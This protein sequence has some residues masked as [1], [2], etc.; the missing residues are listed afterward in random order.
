MSLRTLFLASLCTGMLLPATASLAAEKNPALPARE[1][2]FESDIEPLLSRYNCNSS[3]C[4]GKAEGQN[5]FKLSVFGF[6]AKADHNALVREGRGRRISP[7]APDTSLLLLK[8]A[9][10]IP[11]GGGPRIFE[12][13]EEFQLL[14]DWIA[15]GAPFGR[16]D[17]PKVVR[18][19]LTPHERV[20]SMGAKQPLRVLATYSDGT[21]KDVTRLALFHSNNEGLVKV[22]ERGVV[23]AGHIPGQA[24]IMARFIGEVDVFQ[25]LVPRAEA[26]KEFAAPP[27][28]NFI[29]S[30]VDAQLKK[31]NILPSGLAD[32]AEFLRRVYLDVIG[33]L[34]TPAE[35]RKFLADSRADKRARLVDELIERPEFADYWAL[36]LADLLRVDRLKLTHREAYA[37]FKWIRDSLAA[38]VPFDRIVRELLTAEGPL[39]D[40]P[41]GYF[42]KVAAKPG[43]MANSLSQTFLGVRIACAECHHHPYDRWTQGDYQGMTTFFAQVNV[44]KGAQGEALVAEGSPQAKHPRTG[45]LIQPY[46]LGTRMPEKS[47]EGDRRRVLADWF[48]S[49]DNQW[50]AR[51]LANRLVAHFFGRGLVEPVDD[52]R[53][54]NPAS[55]PELLDALA[56]DVQGASFD[57]RKIIRTLTAS[58]TYQLSS[59][60][61]ETNE[62]DEQNYSRA[63][64]KRLPAEVLFDAVC[65]TTGVPEKFD[66]VSPGFRA[67]QLWDSQVQHYFLKLFGRP[68]RTSACECER[69]A[70]ASIAQ[71]LHLLNSPEIQEKLAHESGT[72]ATLVKSVSSDPALVDELYLTWFSRLPTD[73][74]KV[75]A[76]KFLKDSP[77]RRQGAEDLA[78]SLQNSL[79]F[80]FNH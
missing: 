29:D 31:L 9:G 10:I 18:V 41:A 45:E 34:P 73:A 71:V 39:D 37:Y 64:F 53:A 57:L 12:G 63:L 35:A 70:E 14:R 48:T 16:S 67:V 36:K 26:L 59:K 21:K 4:H 69:N 43:D 5:G 32:D 68:A 46:A 40:A 54:T 33:M 60:P 44:K 30:L 17:A 77:L 23:T 6:D 28:F 7:A 56:R 24:A 19:E 66:G 80:I 1:F 72:V 78:W 79:E 75:T 25:A 3:G 38:N 42:Y 74:E 65:Q 58:R 49:S 55:N 51:N 47:P 13:T 15:A 27:Q 52:V 8:A 20:L 22:D 2:N 62:R 76:L 61:N 11:H 50:F